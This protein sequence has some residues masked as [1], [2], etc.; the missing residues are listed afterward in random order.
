M[1]IQGLGTDRH[2]GAAVFPHTWVW[3]NP[4]DS[5]V[6]EGLLLVFTFPGWNLRWSNFWD[7]WCHINITTCRCKGKATLSEK[8]IFIIKAGELRYQAR[9][10]VTFYHL[11][12]NNGYSLSHKQR[13]PQF[14]RNDWKTFVS[15]FHKVQKK[16][17]FLFFLKFSV[18]FVAC[19][20]WMWKQSYGDR[21]IGKATS[22]S[23]WGN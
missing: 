8:Q 16:F 1:L 21:D 2:S 18:F 22:F 11:M 4:F 9:R 14:W 12:R 13:W 6:F 17:F 7:I 23:I 19:G 5:P 15:N 3:L 20:T 10:Q